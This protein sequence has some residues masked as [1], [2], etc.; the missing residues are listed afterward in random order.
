MKI[1]FKFEFL[2]YLYHNNPFFGF[3]YENDT[4]ML[5]VMITATLVCFFNGWYVPMLISSI[6][7]LFFNIFF[8]F[9]ILIFLPLHLYLISDLSFWL[10]MASVVIG[11]WG[12]MRSIKE[13]KTMVLDNERVIESYNYMVEQGGGREDWVLRETERLII[14]S[15]MPGIIT[16]QKDVSPHFLG[17]KRKFLIVRHAK[18]KEFRMFIGA[19][20]FGEHLDASWFLAVDPSFFKR[21]VSK[22]TTGNPT[23]LSQRLDFFAQQDIKAFKAVSDHC[24][25]RALELL[26]EELKLDPSG[27]NADTKGFLNAW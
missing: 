1:V 18:Y 13:V 25:K 23:A 20:S 16:E 17:D 10:R 8:I 15:N 5:P 21:I 26:L 22:H 7:L 19:R 27:L 14:D 6:L 24:F 4:L 9:D 12:L 2:T 3:I 11:I